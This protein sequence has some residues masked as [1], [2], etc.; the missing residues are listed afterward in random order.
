MRLGCDSQLG[1]ACSAPTRRQPS[2]AC[3]SGMRKFVEPNSMHCPAPAVLAL[4]PMYCHNRCYIHVDASPAAPH[5]TRHLPVPQHPGCL[6]CDDLQL[7]TPQ[8]LAGCRAGRG[9]S[10]TCL[11]STY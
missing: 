5:V 3:S 4:H 11:I 1:Q 8:G 2:R 6:Q 9:P 10:L 7:A